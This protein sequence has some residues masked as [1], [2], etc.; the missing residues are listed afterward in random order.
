MSADPAHSRARSA[1]PGTAPVVLR[2]LCGT[3]R[4][5]GRV[6]RLADLGAGGPLLASA[7]ADSLFHGLFGRDA[8]R[9]AMDLLED[10]PQVARATLLELARLQGVQDNPR[11][12]EEPGRI[13]R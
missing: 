5:L 1:P 13:L 11:A 9:M 4:E 7:G 6:R 10:F 3:L 12:E 8:I 2:P